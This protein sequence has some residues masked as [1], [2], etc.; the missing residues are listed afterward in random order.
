MTEPDERVPTI[1]RPLTSEGDHAANWLPRATCM[2][3]RGDDRQCIGHV[4]STILA[5]SLDRRARVLHRRWSRLPCIQVDGSSEG[6]AEI[7]RKIIAS[8]PR[9]STWRPGFGRGGC[10]GGDLA[11]RNKRREKRRARSDWQVVKRRRS[12]N[13]RRNTRRGPRHGRAGGPLGCIQASKAASDHLYSI[14]DNSPI[15]CLQCRTY[16]RRV[17]AIF[18]LGSSAPHPAR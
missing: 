4:R 6:R 8:P 16:A 17:T 1:V 3:P 15:T 2:A 12:R 14:L 18:C 5:N 13:A 11:G 10:L 7:C 9:T